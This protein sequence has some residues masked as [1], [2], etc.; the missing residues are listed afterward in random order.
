MNESIPVKLNELSD[1]EMKSKPCEPPP[2]LVAATGID[3][4]GLERINPVPIE[5]EPQHA[6]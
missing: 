1:E 6:R 2:S 3:L 5:R 4:E